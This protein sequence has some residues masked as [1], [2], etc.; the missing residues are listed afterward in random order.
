MFDFS[1]KKVIAIVYIYII[2]IED[3]VV[4]RQTSERS[5]SGA[6]DSCFDLIGSHQPRILF[7]TRSGTDELNLMTMKDHQIRS[8]SAYGAEHK[9]A[10]YIYIYIYIYTHSKT[11]FKEKRIWM[12]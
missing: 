2:K 8:N 12:I 1:V 4:Y 11:C 7:S 5:S 9:V 10:V 6:Q 3:L